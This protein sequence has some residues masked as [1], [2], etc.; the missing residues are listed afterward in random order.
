MK[1]YVVIGLGRFGTALATDLKNLGNQVLVLDNDEKRVE[2]IKDKVDEAVI[3]DATDKEVLQEFIDK[4]VDGVILNLG[5]AGL[6]AS[7]LTTLN[8]VAMEI[9][10]IV[11]KVETKAFGE[12]VRAIGATDVVNPEE[13]GGRQLANRLHSSNLIEYIPLAPDHDIIEM[14]VPDKFV[15]KTLR[16]LRLKSKLGVFVIA[17]KN[18]ETDE[19][20]LIPE[21]DYELKEDFAIVVIGKQEA[22]DKLKE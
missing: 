10:R 15:G 22:L 17:V 11:V 9:E 1:S 12:I 14:T 8:L 3:G 7:A 13:E 18:T 20:D 6:E 19:F 2:A 5:E 4:N 21:P 16:D